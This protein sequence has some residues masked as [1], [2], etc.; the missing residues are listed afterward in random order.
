MI[1]MYA[2]MTAMPI[3]TTTPSICFHGVMLCVLEAVLTGKP[4]IAAGLDMPRD[5]PADDRTVDARAQ[6]DGHDFALINTKKAD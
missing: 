1:V 4:Q 5:E 2:G 6:R 3:A